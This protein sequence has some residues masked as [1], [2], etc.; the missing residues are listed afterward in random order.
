MK[1]ILRGEMGFD[2]NHLLSHSRYFFAITNTDC[3]YNFDGK[4]RR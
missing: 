3:F 1:L 2:L 4:S